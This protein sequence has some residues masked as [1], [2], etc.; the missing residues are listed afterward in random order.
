VE[1]PVGGGQAG[2]DR[3]GVAPLPGGHDAEVPHEARGIAGVEGKARQ[4]VQRVEPIAFPPC[5]EVRLGEPD[6]PGEATAIGIPAA[7][8]FAMLPE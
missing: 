6:N 5:G 4:L 8:V 3:F 7:R 1:R 2:L